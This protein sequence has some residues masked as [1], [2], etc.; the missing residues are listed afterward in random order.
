[1]AHKNPSTKCPP[2]PNGAGI[3][4]TAD[5]AAYGYGSNQGLIIGSYPAPYDSVVPSHR[6]L[7]EP[8]ASG[9]TRPAR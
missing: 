3:G 8:G 4:P 2:T 9:Q 1:M 6:V 5:D 7:R